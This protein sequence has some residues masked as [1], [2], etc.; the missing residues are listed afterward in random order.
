MVAATG[1]AEGF[2]VVV[3]AIAVAIDVALET[4][5]VGVVAGGAVVGVAVGDVAVAA[6][7]FDDSTAVVVSKQLVDV[8][9]GRQQCVDAVGYLGDLVDAVEAVAAPADFIRVAGVEDDVVDA[10]I[11]V[12]LVVEDAAVGV[13]DT[14][15]A[16]EGLVADV[17]DD[18]L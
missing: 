11:E 15:Y 17:A 6:I 2:F 14:L 8:D 16:T 12:T 18:V 7:V 3:G 13:F 1:V 5:A 9:S 10:A 4:V